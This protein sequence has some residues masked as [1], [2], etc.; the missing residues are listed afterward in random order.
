MQNRSCIFKDRGRL[1]ILLCICYDSRKKVM[2]FYTNWPLTRRETTILFFDERP[3]KIFNTLYITNLLIKINF[4]IS[5]HS[6]IVLYCIF[7]QSIISRLF[8][9]ILKSEKEMTIYLLHHSSK[10]ESSVII[11]ECLNL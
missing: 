6:L 9:V 10:C 1:F 4:I 2:I 11:H 7:A 3:G 5:I 8:V